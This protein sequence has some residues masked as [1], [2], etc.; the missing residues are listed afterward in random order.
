MVDQNLRSVKL[1]EPHCHIKVFDMSKFRAQLVLIKYHI[2]E[3]C[4]FEFFKK[5]YGTAGLTLS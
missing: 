3:F 4:A 2:P 1:A 5:T